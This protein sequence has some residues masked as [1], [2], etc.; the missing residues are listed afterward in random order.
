MSRI[1]SL[2]P[3]V[4]REEAV[5]QFSPAGPAGAFRRLV[6]GPL[7]SVA[8]FYI[9]FRLFQVEVS[10]AG[11]RDTR[12]LGLEAVVGSLD[13]YRFEQI[14]GSSE[15]IS[16]ETRNHPESRLDD[17]RAHELVVDKFRRALYSEG[18]FRMRDLSITATPLPGDLHIPYWVGFR[19]SGARAQVFVI[20]A[21]RRQFEG[22]KVRDLLQNWLTGPP[23]AV[24]QGRQ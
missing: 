12:I 3:N 13:L 1:R 23:A 21:V 22:A 5:E 16:V 6:F 20:D 18:F 19:G 24:L 15:I 9:P 11:K 14:P 2:R 17:A 7:R 8:D 10:N 4:T